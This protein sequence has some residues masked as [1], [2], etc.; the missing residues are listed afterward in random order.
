[1]KV[2]GLSN[3]K[4]ELPFPEMEATIGGTALRH[5]KAVG[6]RSLVLDVFF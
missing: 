2:L 1:M 5:R 6:I 4:G 3:S